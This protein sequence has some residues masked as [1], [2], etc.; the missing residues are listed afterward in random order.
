VGPG[1][2]AFII[3]ELSGNHNGSYE[4]AL[5]L[6]DAAMDAGADAVKVQ[7]YTADSMTLVAD[8]GVFSLEGTP[9][10]GRTL[11]DLYGEASMPW[12]WQPK[13][14]QRCAARGIPFFSTPFDEASVKFLQEMGVPCWKVASFELTDV[15]LL[16]H[17][18]RSGL[19][20]I[21]ST[22]M[23][24][25]AEIERAVR[26]LS[27]HGC[28][29]VA[30]L[31][32]TSAYPAPAAS[33]HLRTLADLHSRFGCPV[34]LSDHTLDSTACIASVALGGSI[35]EKHLTL[36]R[37]DGGP[38]AGFSLEPQEFAQMVHAV[39]TAE[40]SLGQ[41]RYGASDAD[42]GSLKY[43][44]AI[45]LRTSIRKGVQIGAADLVMLR[46]AAGLPPTMIDAVV[47]ST[48][49]RDAKAGEPVTADMLAWKDGAPP[50]C[51]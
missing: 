37:S 12:D 36:L 41:V 42:Q 35:I 38:D 43:R 23:G 5:A 27:T 32:C 4:R 19:P 46:P 8:G 20:V 13:L 28:S 48:L 45:F 16:R 51:C 9:W 47:G 10:A 49:V 25:L 2:P 34:G 50:A 15:P 18:A 40:A 6:V 30:L 22:G 26:E 29:S 7:T 14:A 3:A 39:R 31:K 1:H 11:H 21:V 44:R 24:S 33:L 17:V